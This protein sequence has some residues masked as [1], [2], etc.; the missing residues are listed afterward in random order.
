M[1]VDYS[2]TRAWLS[3]R[4]LPNPERDPNLLDLCN[5]LHS[6]GTVEAYSSET[7]QA[8]LDSLQPVQ[9][10]VYPQH[11]VHGAMSSHGPSVVPGLTAV[12]D[13]YI[14]GNTHSYARPGSSDR[15]D[16]V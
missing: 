13:F 16:L 4:P 1:I 3:Q 12:Q 7:S 11:A 9:Y 2:A 10:D 6:E 14:T 8:F 5:N 15:T